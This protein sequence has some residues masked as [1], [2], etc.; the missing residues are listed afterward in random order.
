MK[1][2]AILLM[3]AAL[4]GSAQ[5]R[6]VV[7]LIDPPR[8]TL[9][10]GADGKSPDAAQLRAAIVR[11]GALHQWT[12]QSE[13]PGKLTLRFVKESKHEVVVAVSYDPTGFEIHYVSSIDMKYR[14]Q[15]GTAEIHP[16][17][18]KWVQTLAEDIQRAAQ[19]PTH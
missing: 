3:V 9:V 4:A 7:P 13:E 5:A 2:L 19:S 14:M 12:V 17:Y 1:R 11:G 10:P 15:G 8:V 16:Y 18:N 6:S